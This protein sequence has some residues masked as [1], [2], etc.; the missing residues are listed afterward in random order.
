MFFKSNK[1]LVRHLEEQELL[2]NK[3]LK[4][5]FLKVD[6][7]NFV[8]KFLREKAYFDQPLPIGAQQTISQ[9]TTVAFMLNLLKVKEGDKVLDIGAGSGW[10]SCLLGYLVGK[11]GRVFAYEI[12]LKVGAKGKNNV[13][14]F[15]VENVIYR[16]EAAEKNWE[17]NA[18]YDR[19]L[20]SASFSKI[21]LVLKNQLKPQGVLVAPTQKNDIRRITRISQDVFQEKIFP[22]F[23]FVPFLE[24]DS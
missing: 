23:V 8:S 15:K 18:P 9:P 22:G 6:R 16:I 2:N 20:A 3:R 19:I 11:Q 13:Q 17:K 1:E 5:A 12:N 7:V 24:K 21:P 10:T 4:E 14:R